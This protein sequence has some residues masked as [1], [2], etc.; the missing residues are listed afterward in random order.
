M[1]FAD[2]ADALTAPFSDTVIR[3]GV[4]GLSRAGKTVSLNG[5][6]RASAMSAKTTRGGPFQIGVG[7]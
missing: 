5:A 2:I 4:T 3:L 7:P 1:V 6:V